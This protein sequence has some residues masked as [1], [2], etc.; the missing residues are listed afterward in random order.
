LAQESMGKAEKKSLIRKQQRGG[1]RRNRVKKN[2]IALGCTQFSPGGRG[3]RSLEEKKGSGYLK[4]RV[5]NERS[6]AKM[7][8]LNA[9]R[10]G[11]V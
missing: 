8:F 4:Y 3:A 1:K 10:N 11:S 2:V 7:A 9:P 5:R 6:C